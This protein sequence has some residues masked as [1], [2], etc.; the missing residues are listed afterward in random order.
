[1]EIALEKLRNDS[2]LKL[3]QQ[4]GAERERIKQRV[5]ANRETSN[6]YV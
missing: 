5:E 1:M 6:R 3:Q 4:I 2:T